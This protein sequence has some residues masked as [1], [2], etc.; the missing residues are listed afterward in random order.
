VRDRIIGLRIA[1][2]AGRTTVEAL[3]SAVSVPR[4]DWN[5][6]GDALDEL[7]RLYADGGITRVYGEKLYSRTFSDRAGRWLREALD[8]A[9]SPLSE[10]IFRLR[11]ELPP[12]SAALHEPCWEGLRLGS[13]YPVPLGYSPAGGFYRQVTSAAMVKRRASRQA[14]GEVRILAAI[15]DAQDSSH[16]HPGSRTVASRH[17][18]CLA[19]VLRERQVQFV[20]PPLH[21]DTIVE[22]LREGRPRFNALHLVAPGGIDRHGPYIVLDGDGDQSER[23]RPAQLD[24]LIAEVGQGLGLVVLVADHT[25][26]YGTSPW[27]PGFAIRLSRR[28]AAVVAVQ[29]SMATEAAV[30]FTGSFY[31]YLVH[32]GRRPID[33]AVNMARNG[34]LSAGLLS[35]PV[36]FA[37]GD[38]ALERFTPRTELRLAYD[39]DDPAEPHPALPHNRH[40]ALTP[41]GAVVP[42]FRQTPRRA[43]AKSFAAGPYQRGARIGPASKV[44]RFSFIWSY[45]RRES[46]A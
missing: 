35:A 6:L 32:E 17:R 37:H 45:R 28:G 3:S 10:G 13:V 30:A 23:I 31:Q 39:D 22:H 1:V 25:A 15:A 29:G 38:G 46:A 8:P 18:E 21:L 2:M 5:L 4:D 11:L 43:D 27:D 44:S 26:H 7:R 41:T 12:D 16:R 9:L 19:Q 24:P 20:D 40:H 36:L 14:R 33:Q 42:L 34:L